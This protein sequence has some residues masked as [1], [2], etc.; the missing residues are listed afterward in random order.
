MVTLKA[1]PDIGKKYGEAVCVAGIDRDTNDWIRLYP[2]AFRDLPQDRKFAKYATILVEARKSKSDPRP[3]S[4]T[5]AIDSLQV[6]QGPLPSGVAQKRRDF[7]L[8]LIQ[9]GTCSIYAQQKVEGVSLGL[10]EPTELLE[11]KWERTD[12]ECS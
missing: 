1:Y 5:P 4:Y 9:E 3:E 2:V 12:E 10:F 7:I 8:P 6:I 11:F